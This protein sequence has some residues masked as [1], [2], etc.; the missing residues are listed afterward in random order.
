MPDADHA[1]RLLALVAA[2]HKGD[3]AVLFDLYNEPHVGTYR[4]AGMAELV[5]A[6]RSTRAAL[7]KI[8]KSHP[9][10]TGELGEGDCRDTYTDPYMDWADAH[11]ISYLAWPGTPTAAGPAGPDRH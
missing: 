2:E 7:L 9:V 4:A 8:A 11:G 6:V 1:P 3:H 10:V 5:E